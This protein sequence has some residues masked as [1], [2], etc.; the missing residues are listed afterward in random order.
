MT[1]Q[2]K[3]SE[4]KAFLDSIPEDATVVFEKLCFGGNT[5]IDEIES[6][7]YDEKRNS[8]VLHEKPFQSND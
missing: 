1:K 7:S 5:A 8:V 2:L 6:V 3:V 4:L